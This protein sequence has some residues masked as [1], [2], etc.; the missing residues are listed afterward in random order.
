M[1]LTHLT[2]FNIYIIFTNEK[3]FNVSTLEYQLSVN[4]SMDQQL[5]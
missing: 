1:E 2:Y 3:E 4:Y 5:L